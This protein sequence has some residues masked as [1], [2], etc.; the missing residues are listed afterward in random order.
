MRRP[1]TTA[2]AASRPNSVS[3]ART[4]SPSAS[5]SPSIRVSK[6]RSSTCTGIPQPQY[7]AA[8]HLPLCTSRKG[9][10][11]IWLVA[12]VTG[13]GDIQESWE[14]GAVWSAA[15]SGTEDRSD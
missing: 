3:S 5:R 15:G 13:D 2:V 12:P 9:G 10:Y 8:L 11:T 1:S 6:S 7:P 4:S 14:P